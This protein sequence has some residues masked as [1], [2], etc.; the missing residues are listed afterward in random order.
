M[1]KYSLLLLLTLLAWPVLGQA[2][3]A[4]NYQGVARR[5]DGSVLTGSVTVKFTILDNNTPVY[6]EQH[7]NVA[8]NNLGLFTLA[9]GRGRVLQGSFAD[10][11]WASGQ[12][13]LRVEYSVPGSGPLS[14]TVQLLSVPYALYAQNAGTGGQKGDPGPQGVPG[15][16]GPP[17]PTGPTGPPGPQGLKGE[18]GPAGQKGEPGAKGDTGPQGSPGP[19][20]PPGPAG[21]KGE[22]GA[23]GEIGPQGIQG[24]I[25]PPG[26]AGTLTLTEGAGIDIANNTITNTAPDREVRLLNGAGI[27]VTGTYPEFTISST[28]A[29]AAY[30]AGEGLVLEGTTF[31]ARTNDALWNANRLQG[32]DI[33][34]KVPAANDVLQWNA[35]TS[36]W[37]PGPAPAGPTGN[38]TAEGGEA[39]YVPKFSGPT[40]LVRS[41]IYD[42]GTNVGIGLAGTPPAPLA[43]LHV[44]GGS[45]LLNGATGT[46]P[47][48]GAGTRFMWIPA[49]GA[50]RAGTV[51]QEGT[52]NGTNFWDDG[53]IGENSIGLGLNSKA[54]G[55]FSLALGVNN[56]AL[57][58]ADIVIGQG[59][60]TNGSGAFALGSS[61]TI[62]QGAA[63]ALGY[64]NLVNGELAVAVGSQNEI[65]ATSTSQAAANFSAAHGVKNIVTEGSAFAFGT[66]VRV[67][68]P[69]AFVLG[70]R[71]YDPF[72]TTEINAARASAASRSWARNTM[73]MRFDG[74]YR[75]YTN[76]DGSAYV[77]I[78]RNR[79]G[80]LALE[81]PPSDMRRKENFRPI[82]GETV[83][84]K[85]SRFRLTTWN[86]K[87]EDARRYRH[88]GPMAQDF[89]AAFGHD[90]VGT[91]GTDTTIATLDLN[92]LN[93]T[94]IKA[95]VDR[96][97]ALRQ[98]DA[99]LEQ[100]TRELE[101]LM[102]RLQEQQAA[103]EKLRAQVAGQQAELSVQQARSDKL[104]SDLEA[105]KQH[106]GIAEKE[107]AAGAKGRGQ[108]A[109]GRAGNT[110]QRDDPKG[111]GETATHGDGE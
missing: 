64:Q 36:R 75:F 56:Q 97:E 47:V 43:R 3:Q 23:K 48:A 45:V 105:I 95:L 94:A 61:N 24:P 73:T 4:F 92:G 101:A 42:N 78:P 111:A 34:P 5:E 35:T 26:P 52:F 39:N 29:P 59:N 22:P 85:I 8:L 60:T 90:S 50:L 2:P 71:S 70:D 88:Y 11:A 93:F 10:I 6:A 55:N 31:R 58:Y 51:R 65:S 21:Q 57:G 82:D 110:V 49:K 79:N 25:G 46:T 16:A 20:G 1:K 41:N 108:G 81:A 107:T 69:G 13:N 99:Q 86:Y 67:D 76:R 53:F 38:V 14:A 28:V 15:P 84:G 96:T 74:G 106:L 33:D 32:R 17:G 77:S 89:Y 66:L 44:E 54:A 19:V 63:Y 104:E 109:K 12:K 9:I 30:T 27:A 98:K 100:Q 83:L 102:A 62:T 87:G 68:H 40:G 7:D 80:V 91:V 72:V 37:E 103:N 18:T